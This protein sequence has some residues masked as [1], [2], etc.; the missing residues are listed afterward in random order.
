MHEHF[1]ELALEQARESE[2][3]GEVPVG[4]VFVDKG[5]VISASGNQPIG[6]NDPTAHAEILALR[7]AAEIKGN[8]RLGGS[9]YVTLEPCIMCIGALIHARIEHLIFGAF[10]HRAGAAGTIYDF[11][12]SSD[13]NHKFEVLGGMLEKKCQSL[14]KDFFKQRR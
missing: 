14:L 12:N 2:I 9:L 3:S 11:S 13:L 10:D 1:M 7:K 6:L 8:Y 5:E 4:A